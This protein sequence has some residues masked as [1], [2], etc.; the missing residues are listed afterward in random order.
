M[1]NPIPPAILAKLESIRA[2][3]ERRHRTTVTMEELLAALPRLLK[4]GD[5]AW[6]AIARLFRSAQPGE[7][8]EKQAQP[9]PSS[10]PTEP[11]KKPERPPFAAF[12]QALP[13][14]VLA[15][16]PQFQADIEGAKKQ[17][18]ST[19]TPAP[20]PASA[21]APRQAAAASRMGGLAIPGLDD[22][23]VASLVHGI[24]YTLQFAHGAV[25]VFRHRDG[26]SVKGKPVASYVGTIHQSDV[27]EQLQVLSRSTLPQGLKISVQTKLGDGAPTF[28][29]FKRTVSGDGTT[30]VEV[31]ALAA[32]RAPASLDELG[33]TQVDR[34]RKMLNRN[35]TVFIEG[36][37]TRRTLRAVSD[38]LSDRGLNVV[39]VER[40]F[41]A[42]TNVG[43]NAEAI[44]IVTPIRDVHE[45]VQAYRLGER[46]LV[47]ATIH[48]LC[49]NS[50]RILTSMG[51]SPRE[52]ASRVN[53]SMYQRVVAAIH[54]RGATLLT[55]VVPMGDEAV[56]AAFVANELPV[57]HLLIDAAEK[58]RQGEV[59]RETL[60][61]E[62]D[63][64][65]RQL[66]EVFI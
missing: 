36:T 10:A 30:F 51:A 9:A 62:F 32:S 7:V 45:L 33:I 25:Q 54:G 57:R 34:V 14:E 1:S 41:E 55:E 8:A 18:S 64:E 60:F 46:A 44:V 3:L 56:V 50:V 17:P 61:S 37:G 58:L 12:L 38:E 65:Q 28:V 27:L 16:F 52:I 29:T 19:P 21:S 26:S 49:A 63:A 5:P 22:V 35:G 20:A 6:A 59:T 43:V 15:L 13:P 24:T 11:A 42:K 66:L 31:R 23:L 2:E 40:P 53:G 39:W 47:L 4:Q 48:P